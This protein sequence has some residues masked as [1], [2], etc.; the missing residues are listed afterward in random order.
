MAT[1]FG[2]R[3]WRAYL[4][5]Q[6]HRSPGASPMPEPR[7]CEVCSLVIPKWK[8]KNVSTC[9]VACKFQRKDEEAKKKREVRSQQKQRNGYVLFHNCL[10][11]GGGEIDPF[12]P[13]RC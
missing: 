9:S 10:F 5:T 6:S 11:G 8:A 7:L 12:V 4:K 2:P 13:S 3:L 1:S